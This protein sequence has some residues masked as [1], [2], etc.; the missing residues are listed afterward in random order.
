MYGARRTAGSD[1]A[2]LGGSVARHFVFGRGQ[3]WLVGCL[4]VHRYVL[5]WHNIER[6]GLR[7]SGGNLEV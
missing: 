5:M 1:P 4:G 7:D 2:R 6:G 3:S